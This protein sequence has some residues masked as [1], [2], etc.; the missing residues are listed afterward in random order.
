MVLL[1]SCG[2]QKFLSG[3][4]PFTYSLAT[5]LVLSKLSV[6]LNQKNKMFHNSWSYC[7]IFGEKP[8]EKFAVLWELQLTCW[9][10]SCRFWLG[11][12]TIRGVGS[13]SYFHGMKIVKLFG[14]VAPTEDQFLKNQKFQ[15]KQAFS[16]S[17]TFH[18]TCFH[19]LHTYIIVHSS[20]MFPIHCILTWL[21]TYGLYIVHLCDCLY[22]KI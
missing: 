1:T 3:P 6:F 12:G 20:N 22:S 9:S 18:L 10:L 4:K 7:P 13:A 8:S 21:C 5:V 16:M 2:L 11:G 19:T 14:G 15:P 17:S